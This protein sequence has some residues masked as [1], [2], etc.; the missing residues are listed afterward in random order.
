VFLHGLESGPHGGKYRA[1]AAAFGEERVLAPDCRG[2]RTVPERL[3]VA[4]AATAEHADLV[5]VGSSFGGLVAAVLASRHPDRVRS[6]V[7]MAPALHDHWGASVRTIDRVPER[8][9]IVHG[10]QD[11]VVPVAASRAFAVQFGVELI[12]VEDGHRLLANRSL[13]VQLAGARL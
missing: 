4:E 12:E 8:T 9:V 5:V 7:L 10:V 1:L 6:L 11:D 2:L 13:M 3:G